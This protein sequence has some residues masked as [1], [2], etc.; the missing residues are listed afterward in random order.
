MLE[1]VLETLAV[2]RESSIRKV[3]EISVCLETPFAEELENDGWNIKW[4]PPREEGDE[5]RLICRLVL[6][7]EIYHLNH[8]DLFK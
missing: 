4:L 3:I 5:D 6:I 1:W 2:K 8:D 7:I